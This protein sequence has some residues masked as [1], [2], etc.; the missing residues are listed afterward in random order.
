[1]CCSWYDMFI[2]YL[3][4]AMNSIFS[5]I[6]RILKPAICVLFLVSFTNPN[7]WYKS[8]WYLPFLCIKAKLVVSKCATLPCTFV[9]NY[10]P[11]LLVNYPQVWPIRSR[12]Q[13]LC[14]FFCMVS[15]ETYKKYCN[16]YICLFSGYHCSVDRAYGVLYFKRKTPPWLRVFVAPLLAVQVWGL[17]SQLLAKSS[18]GDTATPI[19]GLW[20]S[21]PAAQHVV[22]IYT[23]VIRI[24]TYPINAKFDCWFPPLYRNR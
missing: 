5:S 13:L 6:S 20:L 21:S 1:M 17:N 23:T 24:H 15:L 3:I 4:F 9:D 16:H 11:C 8:W 12:D 19:A 14:V 2:R 7:L 22:Y 18:V 10:V